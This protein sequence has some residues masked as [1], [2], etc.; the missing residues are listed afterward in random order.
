MYGMY[1]SIDSI[2]SK[3][4]NPFL[5][6]PGQQQGVQNNNPFTASNN[7]DKGGGFDASQLFKQQQVGI[8]QNPLPEVQKATIGIA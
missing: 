6:G 8:N 2:G 5:H 7:E 4:K 1:G 3:S